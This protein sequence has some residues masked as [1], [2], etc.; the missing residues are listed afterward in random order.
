[1]QF[2]GSPKALGL[3][4][5]SS[6][7]DG[8]RL[9]HGRPKLLLSGVFWLSQRL[10]GNLALADLK[11]LNVRIAADVHLVRS[12][13]AGDRGLKRLAALAW[14]FSLAVFSAA[15]AEQPADSAKAPDEDPYAW[16]LLF[17]GKTL[18]GWKVP[19]F[20]G[21][22]EVYVQDGRIILG[23]GRMM[24]G[25]ALKGEP[26]RTNY[27][28][29]WEGMRVDGED[30]FCAT[31]FP[32]GKDYCSFVPG[33]WGGMVTGLSNVDYYDASDNMTTTFFEYKPKQWYTF[34]VRV[35]DARIR[36]WIGDEQVVD[37]PR[38]EHTFDIRFEVEPCR[39]LGM[40]SWSTTGA[41]R[42]IRL[43]RLKPS[44]IA[45]P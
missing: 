34:R 3:S 28:L 43:R 29:Q 20:G 22:G 23:E 7:C 13:H 12:R 18:E 45:N 21:E 8:E 4:F 37:Q 1:M 6:K 39:P 33:G 30:F 24:T 38:G 19:S 15:L 44:E 31:T 10:G 25:I 17:D 11:L 16:K 14:G 2:F 36:A 42:N 27:E 35:S 32:V 40:A 41:V 9:R 26:P 5:R